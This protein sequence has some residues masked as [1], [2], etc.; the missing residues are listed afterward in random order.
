MTSRLRADGRGIRS[1]YFPFSFILADQ[2]NRASRK[3]KGSPRNA[4]KKELH[5]YVKPAVGFTLP[6][7]GVTPAPS[8]RKSRN[9]E[10]S[11]S[12]TGSGSVSPPGSVSVSFR[13]KRRIPVLSASCFGFSESARRLL[14]LRLQAS[15]LCACRLLSLCHSERSEESRIFARATRLS[16]SASRLLSSCLSP[17]VLCVILSG[18]KNPGSFSTHADAWRLRVL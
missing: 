2:I 4:G 14:S 10:D 16:E 9:V 7:A 12:P 15:Y 13:A 8:G 11:I 3:S 6:S 5:S 1:L 18:A 17:P